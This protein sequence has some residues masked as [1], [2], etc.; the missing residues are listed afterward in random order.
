MSIISYI[1]RLVNKPN[2]KIY[3][4]E[5][6]LEKDPDYFTVV[7]IF[8]RKGR[9]YPN[10]TDKRFKFNQNG[11]SDDEL[12]QYISEISGESI[13]TIKYHINEKP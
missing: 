10:I 8:D 5:I 11:E 1:K 3:L 2:R 12:L 9:P 6:R 4:V 13:E 7:N